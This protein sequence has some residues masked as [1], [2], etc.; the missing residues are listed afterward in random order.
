MKSLYESY[1]ENVAEIS[2]RLAVNDNFDVIERR[3]AV[4]KGEI[5]LFYI[6]G[7]VKDGVM[8]RIMQQLLAQ[9]TLPSAEDMLR[10]L[11]YVEVEITSDADTETG[12]PRF[13]NSLM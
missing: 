1:K 11:A 12:M 10:R 3:L 2:T 4:G 5:C 13:C 9:K 8:Q 7:F 6:D